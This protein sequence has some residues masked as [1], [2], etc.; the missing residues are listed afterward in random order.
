MIKMAFRRKILE[1]LV[2]A[3]CVFDVG[4]CE[5]GLEPEPEN[6]CKDVFENCECTDFYI[7]CENQ[8]LTDITVLQP[9][10]NKA[11]SS[12][13]VKGNNFKE[14]PSNLFEG[15]TRNLSSLVNLDLSNNNIKILPGDSFQCFDKLQKLD[16][17][18][19]SLQV[20]PFISNFHLGTKTLKRLNLSFAFDNSDE[21][22]DGKKLSRLLQK[23]E[24]SGLEILDLSGNGIK[25]IY[26][27]TSSTLCDLLSLKYLNLSHNNMSI[28]M[29][30]ECMTS[31]EVLDLSFNQ[32][33]QLTPSLMDSIEALVQLKEVRLDNNPYTCTCYI[34][35]M[36]TWLNSTLQPVDK[37]SIVCGDGDSTVI[38][39]PLVDI[40]NI[41]GLY[42][43]EPRVIVCPQPPLYTANTSAIAIGIAIGVVLLACV[44]LATLI[45]RRRRQRY[46]QGAV[47]SSDPRGGD[48]PYKRIA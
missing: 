17:K 37:D 40:Q 8:G 34:Q 27:D 26:Y 1:L 4:K 11:T 31:L 18:N 19:N 12:I 24:L 29:I 42:C 47:K 3:F 22:L 14:L 23:E 16:L 46:D 28:A 15:C 9:Y 45:I 32:L 35:D 5:E 43:P 21:S 41:S 25:G 20:D 38:G 2:L 6:H 30:R 48:P 36:V 10:V 44:V 33:D 7:Y 39:T 13:I